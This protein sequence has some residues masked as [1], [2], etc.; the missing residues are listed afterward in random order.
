[1]TWLLI[2]GLAV[3]ALAPLAWALLRPAST[4]GRAEADRALFTAQRAEIDRELAEGRMDAAAHRGALLELQRRLLAAPAE[5]TGAARAGASRPLV[6][7]ILLVPL[8]SLTLYLFGGFP[9]M[10]SAP[11]AERR[12]QL[13][14]EDALVATLRDRL[15]RLP[16]G[17]AE[18]R[19]GLVL[20]GNAESARGRFAQA[21]E[22]WT[23]ALAIRFDAGIAADVAEI[24]IERG[25]IAAAARLLQRALAE[26]PGEARLRF[27]DGLAAA[28]GGR[29]E[30]ARATWQRLLADAPPNAPWRSAVEG[31]LQALP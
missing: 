13:E 14:Q 26:R 3:V 24:E 1:M 28:R 23:Q 21:A 10:P 20:L 4:R 9:E 16:A 2:L 19:Q 22:A 5:D 12:V 25:Q 27:L 30:V 15:A 17:G 6:A 7:A 29:P 11:Y 31:Q 8:L 18:L